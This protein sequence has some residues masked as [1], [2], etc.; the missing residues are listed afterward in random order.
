MA[1]KK[2]VKKPVNKTSLIKAELEKSPNAS[3]IEIAERLKEHGVTAQYV[4]TVKFNMN[5]KS[6]K[7]KSSPKSGNKGQ[8]V[9]LGDLIKAKKLVD[10]LGGTEKAKEIIL[11]LEKLS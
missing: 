6:A 7:K 2:T 9:N 3:P 5:K 8:Q 4:S 11:A 10:E 1:K